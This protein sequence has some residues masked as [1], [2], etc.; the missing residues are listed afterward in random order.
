[1]VALSGAA[2]LVHAVG[3]DAQRVDVETRSPVSSRMASR[4]SSTAIW[5]ISFRFF[6]PPEKPLFTDRL[7]MSACMSTIAS[8]S[9]IRSANSSGSTSSSPRALRISL[10]AARRKVRVRHA[11]DLDRILKREEDARLGSHLG[12][13]LEQI[14][15]VVRSTV[16]AGDFVRRIAGQDLRQ[17]ALAGAVWAH[18]RVNLAACP[19]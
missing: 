19:R 16:S 10:Y 17:R 9:S 11:R 7:N 13:H 12:L 4:G 8:F 18:D 3:D 5:R 6:S 1:M 2:K 15:S 14:V